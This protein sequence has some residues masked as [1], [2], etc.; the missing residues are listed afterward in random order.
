MKFQT[1]SNH[2]YELLHIWELYGDEQETFTD[3]ISNL[4]DENVITASQ[5]CKLRSFQLRK[6]RK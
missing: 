5:W 6:E 2:Y 4:C 3:F 1:V